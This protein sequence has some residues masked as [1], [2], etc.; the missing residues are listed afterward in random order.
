MY[1]MQ[2]QIQTK[3]EPI[4][5]SLK[6]NNNLTNRMCDLSWNMVAYD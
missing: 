2:Y 5:Q 3:F 1:V 4:N 6:V